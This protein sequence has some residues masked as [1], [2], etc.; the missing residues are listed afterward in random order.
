M[1]T[2]FYDLNFINFIFYII[3]TKRVQIQGRFIKELPK[4]NLLIHACSKFFRPVFPLIHRLR[5]LPLSRENE[6]VFS[7]AF[8]HQTLFELGNILL[9]TDPDN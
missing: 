5:S 9:F 2:L 3:I 6:G 1:I 8:I 7:L 4:D